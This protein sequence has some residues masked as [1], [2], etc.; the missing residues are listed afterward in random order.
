M[1][2]CKKITSIA[3]ACILAVLVIQPVCANSVESLEA[4]WLRAVS[5]GQMATAIQLAN[6]I[7]LHPVK[8]D[9]LPEYA[10]LAQ[11]EGIHPDFFKAAFNGWD[12]QLWQHAWFFKQLA[13]KLTRI[14]NSE[15]DE[16]E[17]L[18][19]AVTQHIKGRQEPDTQVPWPYQI[20]QCGFGVC[21][22]Q[23]WVLCELAYQR[24]WE[25]QIIYLVDPETK[26][27]PHTVCELRQADRVWFADPYK[28]VLLRD[29]S[30]NKVAGDP[31]QLKAIW[32][33][34]PD[35]HAAIA[36]CVFWTPAYPQDYC[37]RNQQLYVR[38]KKVL[39]DR[40]PRFGKDPQTRLADYQLLQKS[41][42]N[43]PAFQM[44]LWPY[45]FRLLRKGMLLQNN[46]R[47]TP[48]KP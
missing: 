36:E 8:E 4:Q 17:A 44:R 15:S 6:Q 26:V 28:Q 13:N 10:K 45:P 1:L 18:F 11:S 34:R 22:R 31:A 37:P 40:C 41:E 14:D 47:R 3:G 43:T 21:D 29:T 24:G 32:P 25:T 16:I 23:A 12:F 42:S 46:A 35:F 5:E 9:V 19:T 20:W 2:F 7:V 30:V 39:K 27:S 38:L 48:Q 33:N